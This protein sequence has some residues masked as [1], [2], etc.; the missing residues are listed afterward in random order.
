MRDTLGHLSLTMTNTYLR[1][2]TDSLDDAFDQLQ[3]RRAISLV[4][5]AAQG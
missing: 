2:R 5:G 1:S 4:K 3:R